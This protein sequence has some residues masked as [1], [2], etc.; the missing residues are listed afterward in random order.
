[1]LVKGTSTGTVTDVEG[2]YT[3]TVSDEDAVLVFSSVGYVTQEVAVNGRTVIDVV[4]EEDLQGLDEVV[5]T[6]YS[7]QRK[8]DITGSVSVV[9]MDAL[10]SIPSGSADRALQGMA[11]GVNVINSGIP[12]AAPKILIRGV[13]SFG[14]TDPLVIIDG[15]AGSLNT[16]NA[17]EIESIQVLKDAGAASIYG[18]RGANGVII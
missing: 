17:S 6:G 8:K 4:L 2:N 11:S 12:G 14:N 10:N 15:I 18:V 9:D 13:T 5:V 3:L 7:T 1:V 16:V